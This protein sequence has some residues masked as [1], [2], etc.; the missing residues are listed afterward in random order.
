[1]ALLQ[2]LYV[3]G[4]IDG[5]TI[6]S[7]PAGTGALE[8]VATALLASCGM[9]LFL[10]TGSVISKI[11]GV[12][13]AVLPGLAATAASFVFPFATNTLFARSVGVGIYNCFMTRL[14]LIGT[15]CQ[16]A[17]FLAVALLLGRKSTT[18]RARQALL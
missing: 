8:I 12:A 2:T 16:A 10:K 5:A 18:S 6:T 13:V 4:R 11:A 17:V 15:S 1:M 7:K 3:L 9:I 14:A